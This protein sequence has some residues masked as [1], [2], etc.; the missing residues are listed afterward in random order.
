MKRIL[1]VLFVLGLSIQLTMA[2][3]INTITAEKVAKSFFLQQMPDKAN[4]TIE[5]KLIQ[6]YYASLQNQTSESSS[7]TPLF[8]IYNINDNEGFVIVTADDNMPPIL[9]YSTSGGY[10]NENVPPALSE[11]LENYKM[12]IVFIIQNK[13]DAPSEIKTEW[14]DL[15]SNEPVRG[16]KNLAGVNP[17][18]TTKWDQGQYYNDYCPFDQTEQKHTY[19]GCVATAMAQI[20]KYWEYPSQGIGFHS[21]VHPDYG[22]LWANYGGETFYWAQMPI[23]VTSTNLIV[24]SMMY[25]CGVSVDMD[26]GVDG[27][28]AYL[29]S[30]VDALITYF[31]YSNSVSYVDKFNFNN[32]SWTQKLK[33]ELN[34]GRPIQYRGQGNGAHSFVC[35]GYD[36]NDFFHFNWGWSGQYN[37]YFSLTSLNP[38]TYDFTTNQAAII[39]IK[40]PAGN[41]TPQPVTFKV[42]MTGQ[43]VSPDGVHIAGNFQGWDPGATLMTHQV[44][45]IYSYTVN[46]DPGTA[47]EYKFINGNNWNQVELVPSMCAVS[48]STFNRSFT[49]PDEPLVL[50]PVCFGSC[51]PCIKP[52]VPVTFRVDMKWQTVSPDGVHIAGNFQDWDPSKTIMTDQGNNFYDFTINLTPGDNIEYKFINGNT[53]A[54]VEIVPSACGPEPDYNRQFVVPDVETIVPAVCFNSCSS[55]PSSLVNVTF[56]VDMTGENISADGIHIAGNFQG[57]NPSTTLMTDMGNNIYSFS[58]LLMPGTQVEYKFI[59]GSNWDQSENIPASCGLLPNNNRYVMIQSVDMVLPLVRFSKCGANSINDWGTEIGNRITLYPNPVS[60]NLYL[61]ELQF[62]DAM[63]TILTLDGQIVSTNSIYGGKGSIN[64]ESLNAGIYFIKVATT[65]EIMVRKVIKE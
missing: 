43:T 12:Q 25:D 51:E 28:G 22:T 49:L 32:S 64:V 65:D 15:E 9:G 29:S 16:T 33:D 47:V 41:G 37:G 55:C 21:Y 18:I 45:G 8:Y 3:R 42:D 31:G 13:L 14:N 7:Q 53:W 52:M 20:M 24:S 59:N 19:V 50:Q 35:D 58:T 5:L 30:V 11:F 54:Q 62:K 10:F 57:W 4:K 40:P 23:Q 38:Y 34:A 46:L 6:T 63:V 36:N 2:K 1:I 39:G 26:Y 60:N 17:L 48:L 27:S 56:K 44:G 61:E